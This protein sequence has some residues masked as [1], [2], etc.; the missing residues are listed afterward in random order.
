MS[1]TLEQVQAERDAL[2]AR[3]EQVDGLF[4]PGARLVL[5]VTVRKTDPS[6]P[7]T[8]KQVETRNGTILTILAG[9]AE[10]DGA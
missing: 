3:L 8:L 6:L 5:R 4:V 1:E 10:P 2:K 7:Q 9:D